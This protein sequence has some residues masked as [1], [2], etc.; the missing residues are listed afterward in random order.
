MQLKKQIEA[1]SSKLEETN[2]SG[3][4]EK[5]VFLLEISAAEKNIVKISRSS[6]IA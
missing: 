1:R 2:K 4:L 3:K 6:Q 5:D